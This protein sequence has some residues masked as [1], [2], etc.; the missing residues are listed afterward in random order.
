M[1]NKQFMY[2]IYNVKRFVLLTEVTQLSTL[3]NSESKWNGYIYIYIICVPQ[4]FFFLKVK[5]LKIIYHKFT[6]AYM[7]KYYQSVLYNSS[8]W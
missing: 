4:S 5:T 1:Y 3:E 8:R 7:T 6:K 2:H